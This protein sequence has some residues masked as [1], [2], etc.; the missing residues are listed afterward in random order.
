MNSYLSSPYPD[1]PSNIAGELVY[2]SVD[3]TSMSNSGFSLV[4]TDMQNERYVKYSWHACGYKVL[5]QD[6]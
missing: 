1:H 4:N 2:S 6:S 5:D 3:V